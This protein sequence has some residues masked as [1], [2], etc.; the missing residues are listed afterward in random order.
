MEHIGYIHHCDDCLE[1]PQAFQS[2]RF[3]SK[4]LEINYYTLFGGGVHGCMPLISLLS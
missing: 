3:L 2:E 4:R 1:N